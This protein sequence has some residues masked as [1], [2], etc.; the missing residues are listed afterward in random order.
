MLEQRTRKVEQLIGDQ[1]LEL[2]KPTRLRTGERYGVRGTDLGASFEWGGKVVLLFGDTLGRRGAGGGDAMG[3]TE[4]RTSPQAG[5]DLRFFTRPGDDTLFQPIA[6]PGLSMKGFEVPVYGVD[7]DGKM[8][9]GCK[10]GHT[11]GAHTD[12]TVLVEVT[13]PD[14]FSVVR[15]ISRLPGGRFIKGSLHHQEGAPS[16]LPAGGPYIYSF[17]TGPYRESHAYFAITPKATFASSTPGTLY[18]SGLDAAGVPQFAPDESSARPI[19]ENG[20]LGD[21]SVTHVSKLGVWLMVYDSRTPKGV[22]ARW[23]RTPWGPYSEPELMF[24]AESA[25]GKWIHDVGAGD[26]IVGPVIAKGKEPK[27]VQGG[28]YAPYVLERYSEVYFGDSGR[29]ELQV[30][31]VLS[32]WNPYV[33]VLMTSSFALEYE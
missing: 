31:Y 33:V 18:F 10:T 6:P 21:L 15:E 14:G 9:I 23:S 25:R 11:E 19:A 32:T 3:F 8:F 20:S 2:G 17:G 29:D 30:Y 1:D 16:G 13:P 28:A 4:Q 7:L 22:F 24:S 5:L 26:A 12:R 27:D